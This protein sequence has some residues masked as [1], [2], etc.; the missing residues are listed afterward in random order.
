MRPSFLFDNHF[1]RNASR[2]AAGPVNSNT[3]EAANVIT[4]RAAV[5]RAMDELRPMWVVR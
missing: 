4:T 1:T 3:S 5:V 2:F